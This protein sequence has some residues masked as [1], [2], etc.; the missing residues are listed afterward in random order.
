MDRRQFLRRLFVG[1]ASV[2]AAMALPAPA[3]P[4]PDLGFRPDAFGL[5]A[6]DLDRPSIRFVRQYDVQPD[7]YVTKMDVYY[8]FAVVRPEFACRIVTEVGA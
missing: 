4:N 5:V 2:A 1:T 3:A 8:G 6:K 7:R